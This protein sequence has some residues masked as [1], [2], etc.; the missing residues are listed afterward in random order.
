M[1]ILYIGSEDENL[2]CINS[3]SEELN[4]DI[5]MENKI[6]SSPTIDSDN[7]NVYIGADTGNISCFDTRDGTFK[8]GYTTGGE[9]QSTPA[10]YKDQIIV[11]SNDG[12]TY[13]LNKY[14]GAVESKFNPGCIIFNSK[15]TASPIIYGDTLIVAD[16]SGYMHS[17]DLNKKENPISDFI[18]YDAIIIIIL[19]IVI[20]IVFKFIKKVNK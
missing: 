14:T 7:N 11:N 10:L 8:W 13:T 17:V 2:Y 16:H 15:I 4:W 6:L 3:E 12:T 1:M 20:I 9:I 19:I 5:N 18:Y